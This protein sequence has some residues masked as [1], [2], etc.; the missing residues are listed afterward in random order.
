MKPRKKIIVGSWKAYLKPA[1]A[2]NLA[3]KVARWWE[4]SSQKKDD[5]E[6]VLSPS[7]PFIPLV[8]DA[9]KQTDI[10]ISSQ[11]VHVVD[12]YGA[13]T[14]RVPLRLLS[15]L[16]CNYTLLGHSELRK[17]ASESDDIIQEKVHASLTMSKLQVILCIGETKEEKK[18]GETISVLK[19]QLESALE[20][21]SEEY[22]K[23][24]FNV[25]Y[26][27]VWA[28]ST[29]NP[30][31]PPRADEVAKVHATIREILSE[32]FDEETVNT[33]RIL[34][35]G[36]VNKENVCDYLNNESID[37]VLVGSASAKLPDF[38]DLLGAVE[39]RVE[40]LA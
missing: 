12:D 21:L 16:G 20:D 6:L 17:G 13:Y 32:K 31:E 33:I 26:E 7:L 35:G 5:Y 28:I 40:L 27:P 30:T 11:D 3:G 2:E 10:Q 36:S 1:Q 23:E 29:E 34:Y 24:R 8:R 38:V 4:N 15:D 25:A 14:G 9:I 39:Q 18:A 22:V 37:G 19:R